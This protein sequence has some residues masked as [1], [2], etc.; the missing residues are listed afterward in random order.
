ME[1]YTKSQ[2]VV[3]RGCDENLQQGARYTSKPVTSAIRACLRRIL[4]RNFFNPV[5]DQACLH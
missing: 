4:Q 2:A 1:R 5:R 3:E